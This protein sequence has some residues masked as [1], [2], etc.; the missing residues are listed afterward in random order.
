MKKFIETNTTVKTKMNDREIVLTVQFPEGTDITDRAW[1]AYCRFPGCDYFTR[2]L[3]LNKEKSCLDVYIPLR[4]DPE[5]FK[6]KDPEYDEMDDIYDS[7]QYDDYVRTG[8]RPYECWGTHLVPM[9]FSK[10]ENTDHT[11]DA[12]DPDKTDPSLGEDDEPNGGGG[13]NIKI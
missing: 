7:M 9:D 8:R 10:F 6:D 5:E 11:D 12:E 13:N 2:I 3:Y 4:Q 1:F